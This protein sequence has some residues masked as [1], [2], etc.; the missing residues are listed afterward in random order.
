MNIR[1]TPAIA[2]ALMLTTSAHAELPDA[3]SESLDRPDLRWFGRVSTSYLN[4]DGDVEFYGAAASTFGGTPTIGMDDGRSVTIAVGFATPSNW[5][6]EG[7]LTYASTETDS[8][9]VSGLGDRADDLFTLDA[10][11]DSLVFMLDGTYDLDIGS[12]R[13]TP[14][15]KGG[16][17][18]ARNT[19]SRA[20]HSLE[21]NS[22]IWAGTVYEGQAL[23]GYDYPDDSSTEFAWRLGVGMRMNLSNNLDL[24][25]EYGY[26]SLG[27]ALTATD[28]NGDAIR[29]TD[30]ASEQASL[31]VEYRFK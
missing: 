13:F 3:T 31:G 5:R 18:V 7:S 15:V 21:Y 10:E 2:F 22:A 26:L 6:L 28:E 4:A 16:L 14:F 30:L 19:S 27:D 9:A 24:A 23:V 17:G 25:L 20:L 11:I 8:G 29:F 1:P 12:S